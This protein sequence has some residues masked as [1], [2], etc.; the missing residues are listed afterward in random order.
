M[1]IEDD[2][3]MRADAKNEPAVYAVTAMYLAIGALRTLPQDNTGLGTIIR[4]LEVAIDKL[5]NR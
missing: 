3:I 5:R 4:Q 1:P 2:E